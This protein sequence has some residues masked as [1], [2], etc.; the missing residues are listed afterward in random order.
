[1]RLF[2]GMKKETRQKEKKGK[3]MKLRILNA[4]TAC[5]VCDCAVVFSCQ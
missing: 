1:M 5:Y 2:D 3:D 4:M